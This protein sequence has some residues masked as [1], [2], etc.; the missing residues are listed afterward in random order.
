MLYNTYANNGTVKDASTAVMLNWIGPS[1]AP[2]QNLNSGFRMYEVDS[3]NFNVMDAH[4]WYSNVTAYPELDGQTEFGPSY[5]YEYSY[6]EAYG[7]N[8]T[9]WGPND[10]L[11]ATWFH[12]V[13][14]Q[15]ELYP[16]LIDDFHQRQGRQS[17]YSNNCT[18]TVCTDAKLCYMRS[19]TAAQGQA[20]TRGYSSAQSKLR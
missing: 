9:G 17:T 5:H 3:G 15:F 4:T 19:G 1:L 20:C 10:P 8:I 13:T 12:K 2:L 11:N 14:E 7:T 16:S 18:S 6:R